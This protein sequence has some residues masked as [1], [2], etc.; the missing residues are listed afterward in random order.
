MNVSEMIKFLKIKQRA[1]ELFVLVKKK[2]K[3][4][5]MFQCSKFVAFLLISN[6]D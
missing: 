2:K 6:E 3:K 5:K 4:K 1:C